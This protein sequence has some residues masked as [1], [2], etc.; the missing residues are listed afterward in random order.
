MLMIVQLLIASTIT[1]PDELFI[2]DAG[3]STEIACF[4][5]NGQI[6]VHITQGVRG[7]LYLCACTKELQ[8]CSDCHQ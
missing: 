1:E 4:G 6:R 2:A 5:D 7:R 3:L 8:C